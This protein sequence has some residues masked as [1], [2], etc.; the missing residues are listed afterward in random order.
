VGGAFLVLF[1]AYGAQYSFGV[2]F[3][4]LLE[5]FGW[6]RASLSGAFS[7]YAFGYSV[8]GFPAGRL[9]D[10]FGPRAVIATGGVFLG[11]AFAGMALVTR[12]WQPYLL[13]G[14]LAA[15]GM[16]T[17][18]V[19]CN[20]T[21]VKWFVRRRGLAVGIASSGGSAGTFV[22]PL[23]AQYL[24]GA[25]GWRGAYVVFGVGTLVLLNV[26]ARMMRRDPESLGLA[27][28]GEAT[29]VMAR[30]DGDA[31]PLARA[32]RTRAFWLLAGVFSTTWL[33]VFI[34]LV[35]LVPLTRDLGF[36][37]GLAASMV[38]ALGVAAVA[39]RLA[40][41]GISD[42]IGRRAGVAIGVVLQALAF[43]L[44]AG[45]ERLTVLYVATI[46]FGFSYG[47]ISTLFPAL[48]GDFFGR[49]QS[50][51]LV[52]FLFALSGS[53][54]AWGPLAAGLV[55]DATG[56]YTLAFLAAAGLNLV[57]LALVLGAHPPPPAPV[58]T[59]M[60]SRMP[61]ATRPRAR[62]A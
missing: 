50:G 17:A 5:E 37:P 22:L 54:A 57:A 53:M 28:D 51:A 14:G 49:A 31:W 60:E 61:A 58:V 20:S 42:R 7:M 35:H 6:S 52:G 15:I 40:M 48:V 2:F 45:A 21:V 25:L 16:G 39:G 46:V 27:P 41:G 3:A 12:L 56:A 4:A 55:Y 36:S 43:L 29:S 30:V 9:T 23:L 38:S 11:A 8:F 18:Y 10:R 13:Y 44:Y 59:P 47:T 33:G 24:V 62:G 1:V 26:V 32:A 34:P 19:P